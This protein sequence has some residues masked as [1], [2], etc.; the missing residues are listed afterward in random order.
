MIA[1]KGKGKDCDINA[2]LVAYNIPDDIAEFA[3]IFD[4]KCKVITDEMMD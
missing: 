4:I 3:S 2:F 1:Y